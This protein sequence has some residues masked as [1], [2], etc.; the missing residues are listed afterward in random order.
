MEGKIKIQIETAK[1][2]DKKLNEQKREAPVS[3]ETEK[4]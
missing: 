4:E 2:S 3:I 1:F